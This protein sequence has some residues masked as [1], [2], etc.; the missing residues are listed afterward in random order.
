VH[1]TRIPRVNV[2]VND[3]QEQQARMN[4]WAALIETSGLSSVAL[5]LLETADA[6][7][8]LVRQAVLTVEPLLRGIASEGLEEPAHRLGSSEVRAQLRNRLTRGYSGDE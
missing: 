6:F 7:G 1:R 2:D 5:S 3:R 8:F 4:R